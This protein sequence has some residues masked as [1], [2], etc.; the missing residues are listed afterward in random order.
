ML[1]AL[2]LCLSFSTSTIAKTLKPIKDVQ[3]ENEVIRLYNQALKY[4]KGDRNVHARVLLEKAAQYDPTAVSAYIHAALSE[5][6]H[7]LGNPDRAIQEGLKALRYNSSMK[8]MYYNLGLYSKDAN[9]YDEAIH[10][11][12]KFSEISSGE[13]RTTAL[14][15]IDSLTKEK[16][17]MGSFSVN[18]PDYLGQLIAENAAH[19]WPPDKVP[20]KVFIETRANAKG[21]RPEFV[22]IARNAFVTWYQASGKKLSFD[23][24]NSIEEADINIEWTDG[25][26]KVGDEKYERTKAGLT[27]TRRV[28]DVIQKARI[29]IRTVRAFSREPEPDDRIKETCLHEIGHALGLH[30]HSMSTSDIMYFGNTARQLPALTRRDKATLARLYQDLPPYPMQGVDTSFP[31]PIH[32]NNFHNTNIHSD[33]TAVQPDS[34]SGGNQSPSDSPEDEHL[35]IPG[36][37]PRTS[38]IASPPQ[39]WTAPGATSGMPVQS[40]QN[41]AGNQPVWA[42]PQVPSW[43]QPNNNASAPG[44]G[45]GVTGNAGYANTGYGAN[46]NGSS[47]PYATTPAQYAAPTGQPWS[48]P[49]YDPNQTYAPQPQYG[50]PSQNSMNQGG[51]YQQTNYVQQAPMNYGQPQQTFRQQQQ[52]QNNYGYN[53]NQNY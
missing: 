39:Q 44:T 29:Q 42:S 12:Q 40:W 30:G 1:L 48:T 24:V 11:L 46:A 21:F 31:P 8:D 10:Y 4:S 19:R 53:Y 34:S 20:L 22:N 17:K 36:D 14:S 41:P 26:L 35:T 23:F 13:K 52:P 27:T 25:S 16:E 7:D 33:Q 43:T 9:R 49:N 6:Y 51:S 15:L 32:S 18:D 3:T 5:I 50:Y 45:Y 38:N 47:M 37:E 28:G 2:A